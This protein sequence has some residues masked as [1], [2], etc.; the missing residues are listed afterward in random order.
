MSKEKNTNTRLIDDINDF[1]GIEESY[2]A[3]DAIM[4]FVISYKDGEWLDNT[5]RDEIFK[6]MLEYFDYDVDFDWFH[7]Y[8]QEEQADRTKKKQDFTPMSVANLL[9]ELV[10]YEGEDIGNYYECCAGTGGIMIARWNKVRRLYSPFTYTPDLQFATVEELSGRTLPFLLFNMSLRGM[11]GVVLN[12]D[13][14]TRRCKDVYFI[15]NKNNDHLAFSEVILT[16]H[17]KELEEEYNIKF[18]GENENIV[19]SKKAKTKKNK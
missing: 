4:D 8:F 2:K 13:T 16:P 10:G 19:E 14:L 17:T 6:K 12:C 7:K 11:N 15:R 18:I 1:L 3:P 9:S 5:K